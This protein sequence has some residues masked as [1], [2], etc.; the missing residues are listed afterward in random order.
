MERVV[1]QTKHQEERK[2]RRHD[3]ESHDREKVNRE[4]EPKAG[5]LER[6]DQLTPAATA[7]S[8]HARRMIRGDSFRQREVKQNG[9]CECESAGEKKGNIDAPAAQD[10]TDRRPKN[11][12]QAKSRADQAH[13]LGAIFFGGD[14]RDVSLRRRDVAAGNSIDDPAEKQHPQ[15]RGESQNHKSK[16]RAQ[17]ADQQNR[18]A[19]MLV[20]Q[21]AHDRRKNQLHNRIG[22]E[23]EADFAG[24]GA[25]LRAFGIERQHRNHDP[26][27]DEI[28][29]DRDEDDEERRTL[30]EI[31]DLA[32]EPQSHRDN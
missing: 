12:T 28:D 27:A 32:T 23:Q 13:S 25:E 9:I 10:A 16:T 15:R 5:T 29:E 14:I 11:K 26:K 20:R 3:R 24:R 2:H 19:A 17:N 6:V 8:R 21:P 31:R 18:P 30:H 4:H 7:G 22:S 1:T